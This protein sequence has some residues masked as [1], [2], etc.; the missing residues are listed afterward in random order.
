MANTQEGEPQE[1]LEISGS[2]LTGFNMGAYFMS[3]KGY[4]EQIYE[5]LSFKPY[6]GTLNIKVI[7]KDMGSFLKLRHSGGITVKGFEAE[8][9]TF[10]DAILHRA[11]IRGLEC[12][13]IIPKLSKHK[14]VMEVISERNLRQAFDLSDG[15][16]ITVKVYLDVS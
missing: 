10:G 15:S 8:G 5:K 6:A 16:V 9:K 11:E 12:A 3:Q 7:E 1:T 13:V 14:D 4:V 2:V